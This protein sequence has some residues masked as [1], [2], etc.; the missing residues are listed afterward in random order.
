MMNVIFDLDGTI[1]DTLPLC[2][3]AFRKA[4]EPILG[5]T[6]T[7]AEIV[8]TFGVSE[9]GIIRLFAPNDYER[10]LKGY[11]EWYRRLHKD[12]P[13]PFDGITE[14]LQLLRK[15]GAFVGM[16]T[17]KGEPTTWI[18]LKKFGIAKYF[19]SV[20]TGSSKGAVKDVGIAEIIAENPFPKD[21]YLYVGDSPADVDACRKA[22]IRIAAAGWAKTTD[23]AALKAKDPDYFFNSVADLRAFIE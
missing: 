4:L 1:G 5:R 15:H 21:S 14:V 11:V 3:L 18:T 7:E 17:G 13:R 10:G 9:E 19:D 16:V 20:K 8:A 6:V 2:I 22:G 23:C 12:W